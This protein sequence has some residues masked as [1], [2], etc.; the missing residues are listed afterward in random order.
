MD[1]AMR[2]RDDP[3]RILRDR[4]EARG[5]S[6]H[7]LLVKFKSTAGEM[8]HPGLKSNLKACGSGTHARATEWIYY[9][10]S[11]MRCSSYC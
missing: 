3:V 1:G 10:S 2:P 9:S 5:V 8:D 11:G 4:L 6:F 7:R